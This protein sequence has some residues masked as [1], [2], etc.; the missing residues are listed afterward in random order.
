M[1]IRKGNPCPKSSASCAGR[2]SIEMIRAGTA[3]A[4]ALFS[5]PLNDIPRPSHSVDRDPPMPSDAELL[6]ALA[7]SE[8]DVAAGRIVPA[9]VLHEDLGA[10]PERIEARR[11]IVARR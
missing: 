5:P 8:A 7:R 11:G 9:S 2:R 6:A 10:A 1:T 3:S 4:D